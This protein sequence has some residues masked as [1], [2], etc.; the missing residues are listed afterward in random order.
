[1]MVYYIAIM[2]NHINVLEP[3]RFV[4]KAICITL[5]GAILVNDVAFASEEIRSCLAP[6]NF[7][8]PPC[9]ITFNPQ[10]G[11]AVVTEGS[12]E[13]PGEVFLFHTIGA[14]LYQGH[15][16]EELNSLIST[17]I[18]PR[19]SDE[20]MGIYD[21]GEIFMDG[22]DFVLPTKDGKKLYVF[23]KTLP[24]D[25][26][27]T[28]IFI[29]SGDRNVFVTEIWLVRKP[30]VFLYKPEP[31]PKK[32]KPKAEDILTDKWTALRDDEKV[33]AMDA[34]GKVYDVEKLREEY[35]PALARIYS[36]TEES[37]LVRQQAVQ[38]HVSMKGRVANIEI[39]SW[40][41]QLMSTGKT[42]AEADEEL[43]TLLSPDAL[44]YLLK[45]AI[46]NRDKDQTKKLI[47]I[48]KEGYDENF[49]FVILGC[50]REKQGHVFDAERS[51]IT[52]IEH[53]LKEKLQRCGITSEDVHS[54]INQLS[55]DLG[56][57]IIG[58][59]LD[60]IEPGTVKED[61]VF[62]VLGFWITEDGETVSIDVFAHD[63]GGGFDL[64]GVHRSGGS[65]KHMPFFD[66][67]NRV[68]QD[69]HIDDESGRGTLLNVFYLERN[70]QAWSYHVISG[71]SR[72][73]IDNIDVAN[74]SI[75]GIT[76]PNHSLR[77]GCRAEV[78]FEVEKPDLNTDIRDPNL[79]DDSKGGKAADKPT[80]EK[81]GGIAKY[82]A[83]LMSPDEIPFE[84]P[85]WLETGLW[86]IVAISAAMFI[87]FVV[88]PWVRGILKNI[89]ENRS[90]VIEQ[91]TWA[92]EYNAVVSQIE[93]YRKVLLGDESA[94][95]KMDE[96]E[97]LSKLFYLISLI[98]Q[99]DDDP[100]IPLHANDAIGVLEQLIK[101]GRISDD[102]FDLIALGLAFVATNIE[103]FSRKACAVLRKAYY[104]NPEKPSRKK[105]VVFALD[106]IKCSK[107]N[108]F[109]GEV[110]L[111]ISDDE[112][113]AVREDPVLNH[114]SLR[115][116]L[117]KKR[118]QGVES[119][120]VI[121]DMIES[122]PEVEVAI[123]DAIYLADSGQMFIGSAGRLHWQ[124]GGI[125]LRD[126]H[127]PVGSSDE[128]VKG[129]TRSGRFGPGKLYSVLLVAVIGIPLT[130]IC[131]Q[132]PQ[133]AKILLFIASLFFAGSMLNMSR[134]DPVSNIPGA[135]SRTTADAPADGVQPYPVKKKG[136]DA[137]QE[138][139]PHREEGQDEGEP[140]SGYEDFVGGQLELREVLSKFLKSRTDLQTP[141]T[142]VSEIAGAALADETI[143]ALA[144]KITQNLPL[145]AR[146]IVERILSV[147]L[148]R[149]N[150]DNPQSRN[151]QGQTGHIHQ[152]TKSRKV[153]ERRL[154]EIRENDV[155]ETYRYR[156]VA[157]LDS[158]LE[159]RKLNDYQRANLEEQRDR[160]K[161]NTRIYGFQ[162]IVKG[163]H[164][165]FL[166]W[167][168]Y[169]NNEIF[170]AWDL[171]KYL[172]SRGPPSLVDEY[173]LHE[174]ICPH[175]KF[176]PLDRKSHYWSIL[177][178]QRLYTD[179]YPDKIKLASQNKR[180]PYKG[181]LGHAIR[182]YINDNTD[183]V[184]FLKVSLSL[185]LLFELDVILYAALGLIQGILLPEI[186]VLALSAMS[187]SVYTA[188][189]YIRNR[190]Y[191]QELK[192][193][194]SWPQK[195]PLKSLEGVTLLRFN[196]EY[197]NI[198]GI[199]RY[200]QALNRELLKRNRMTII[201]VYYT[202]DQNE[203][204][205]KILDYDMG[206]LVLV[207]VYSKK[208]EKT[209]V[210]GIIKKNA[211][212]VCEALHIKRA[213]K[214]FVFRYAQ[215]I[216]RFP[217]LKNIFK[218]NEFDET[219]MAKTMDKV[220]TE[221]DVDLAGIH[222]WPGAEYPVV[223]AL[224][225]HNIPCYVQ[226]H[227][228]NT[229]L[230]RYARSLMQDPSVIL[231]GVNRREV[232]KEYTSRFTSL[233]DGIDDS[234]FR[235]GDELKGCQKGT[236]TVLLP[237]RIGDPNKGHTD[238][239][240]VLRT[241]EGWFEEDDWE[242]FGDIRIV[243]A[244]PV[245]DDGVKKQI[246]DAAEWLKLS[247]SIQ[248]VGGL[249][250]EEMRDWYAKSDVVVLPTQT[251]GLP[252]VLLE[253]Q[254]MEKPVVAYGVGGVPEAVLNGVSGYV[255]EHGD[256]TSFAKRLKMLLTNPELCARMGEAGRRHVLD[257][258]ALDRLAERHEEFYLKVLNRCRKPARQVRRSF[259]MKLK[260]PFYEK[261]EIV[262]GDDIPLKVLYEGDNLLI[263]DTD[264]LRVLAS[265]LGLNK[266]TFL[267]GVNGVIRQRTRFNR[268]RIKRN[269]LVVLA[270]KKI[271]VRLCSKSK[272]L[273][274]DDKE[275]GVI[276][277]NVDALK[278]L[279]REVPADRPDLYRYIFALFYVGFTHELLGHEIGR[280]NEDE[281]TDEDLVLFDR[282]VVNGS[283]DT[284]TREIVDALR[285]IMSTVVEDGDDE[286]I[287]FER[288]TYEQFDAMRVAALIL[289]P[290]RIADNCIGVVMNN[291]K[292]WTCSTAGDKDV[293]EAALE[294]ADEKLRYVIAMFRKYKDTMPYIWRLVP[295]IIGHCTRLCEAYCD[296]GKREDVPIDER[297][298][299]FNLAGRWLDRA[300]KFYDEF[301]HKLDAKYKDSLARQKEFIR[302]ARTELIAC[303]RSLREMPVGAGG[304]AIGKYIVRSVKEAKDFQGKNQGTLLVRAYD[305]EQ[306][307]DV[308]LRIFA[309]RF[310]PGFFRRYKRQGLSEEVR[311]GLD[312]FLNG[313]EGS[314]YRLAP[315]EYHLYGI[316]LK[317]TLA[318]V[319]PLYFHDVALFHELA[320][321]AIDNGDLSIDM[322]KTELTGGGDISAN[323]VG[324]GIGHIRS[325]RLKAHEALRYFQLV[326]WPSD[327]TSLTV[328]IRKI[329]EL[330]KTDFEE[331][332]EGELFK[333]LVLLMGE[334]TKNGT[335]SPDLCH[336]LMG[337]LRWISTAM[338]YIEDKEIL[339]G[340][341]V[342]V[343]NMLD[344]PDYVIDRDMRNALSAISSKVLRFKYAKDLKEEREKFFKDFRDGRRTDKTRAGLQLKELQKAARAMVELRNLWKE[345]ISGE[346]PIGFDEWAKEMIGK[347]LEPGDFDL[348]ANQRALFAARLRAMRAN[349]MILVKLT[350]GKL[351]SID[352]DLMYKLLFRFTGV[353]LDS[354]IKQVRYNPELP[355]VISFE[356][357]DEDA[358]YRFL[359]VKDDPMSMAGSQGYFD[360]DN[361]VA[362]GYE[363][364]K[365]DPFP[366]E[367]NHGFFAGVWG[368][369]LRPVEIHKWT[370]VEKKFV[371][372]LK[373]GSIQEAA[374]IIDKLKWSLLDELN[375]E[376][377]AAITSLSGR[378][379]S[380]RG[381]LDFYLNICGETSEDEAGIIDRIKTHIN[382]DDCS[383]KTKK[384]LLG[385]LDKMVDSLRH[386]IIQRERIALRIIQE[387][388]D[389]GE[390]MLYLVPLREYS[391]FEG[392]YSY[393]LDEVSVE[394]IEDSVKMCFQTEQLMHDTEGVEPDHRRA[395]IAYWDI[396]NKIGNILYLALTKIGLD[397]SDAFDDIIE[398]IYDG[399]KGLSVQLKRLFSERL[400][401]KR[402][403]AGLIQIFLVML[404][405]SHEEIQGLVR[406]T[407][408]SASK[409]R[410]AAQVR[411]ATKALDQ[412]RKRLEGEDSGLDTALEGDTISAET[413][414]NVLIL[415]ADD[416]LNNAA[417]IDME[418]ALRK[419]TAGSGILKGGK[420]I[421]YTRNDKLKKDVEKLK[422]LIERASSDVN[423]HVVTQ[424][425]VF[426][427]K[428]EGDVDDVNEID[429][430]IK[431]LG[432]IIS[433]SSG[434]AVSEKIEKKDIFAIVRGNGISYPKFIAEY[435]NLF[436]PKER[437]IPVVI[438]NGRKNT[439]RGLFSFECI[440]ARILQYGSG[441]G[442]GSPVIL[443]DCV[444]QTED[445]WDG[446]DRHR[447]RVL[448]QL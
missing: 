175:M 240:R 315:N 310:S 92:I 145:T 135:W 271:K 436:R 192:I 48:I 13:V 249:T 153:F 210:G 113:S 53:S 73:V 312:S 139:P 268:K 245:Y 256:S 253:A 164:D 291:E 319:S 295:Y 241:M 185:L 299:C 21:K 425:T 64:E 198:G 97:A 172:E 397:E 51:K 58:H 251:E 5:V 195:P 111:E 167:N 440:M 120:K 281:L 283:E 317:D 193:T 398:D 326:K 426:K 62:G 109:V 103:D 267:N 383:E 142:P 199:E 181:R 50:M 159:R 307:K 420:I 294:K 46:D 146:N 72:A 197:T 162:S 2:T 148:G 354:G 330:V 100:D 236:K 257:N 87:I 81:N 407:R 357:E 401:R 213:V 136:E 194:R 80:D 223:E 150:I 277:I 263:A 370:F 340:L 77:H 84:I 88:I 27:R 4:F 24:K 26:S 233:Y 254:L 399:D 141:G 15:T 90:A 389:E 373:E 387:Q 207:P 186:I 202:H 94:K 314:A 255:V 352:R 79:P 239:I 39:D 191:Q 390:A 402:K 173:L 68:T 105:A 321:A 217:I 30:T 413:R 45:R 369:K 121:S 415:Y 119:V 280:H 350:D 416:I 25:R 147:C 222:N 433:R 278:R 382:R 225:R 7:H 308:R 318:L 333:Y 43:L 18:D 132:N 187:I 123:S 272:A 327:D 432:N 414:G 76:M 339:D 377:L 386:E 395:C 296:Y 57:N 348:P 279:A 75:S 393:N 409:C 33:K 89:E 204:G 35:V 63:N 218:S 320:H 247:D 196:A 258:F 394:G 128:S 444:P 124:G 259:Q 346:T 10:D 363:S 127:Q 56:P 374:D 316:G 328:L 381:A 174:V 270:E 157:L 290:N 269:D 177:L 221:Y 274:G 447:A 430:L 343:D 19:F 305:L 435:P 337:Y 392:I 303:K 406:K 437:K 261:K 378:L 180:D 231:A 368:V 59:A 264:G 138:G 360:S 67:I 131:C 220:L 276:T 122:K 371:K 448:T 28:D 344:N 287:F 93:G 379:I 419:I 47:E 22:D 52:P 331:Y 412:A 443:V 152:G 364:D 227:G 438:M 206:R 216:M 71:L 86:V 23:S 230:T 229:G 209:T 384:R 388:G 14:S 95:E 428:V 332:W 101:S 284:I 334:E 429:Q 106:I 342:L 203:R 244:G 171:I 345:N 42:R 289:K 282:L 380:R 304:G 44:L 309:E 41:D 8:K 34:L 200:L 156:M 234:L 208:H 85:G 140:Y 252:R 356:F 376:F 134:I 349:Y 201:Q 325:K 178:Q 11:R 410:K 365:L 265:N 189:S 116:D 405:I 423:V 375:C 130:M 38:F 118:D 36:D 70:T 219:A 323:M 96:Y 226:A 445:L 411:S 301:K 184:K 20:D 12:Y 31:E 104:N 441:E 408:K 188:I 99:K 324:Q 446:I 29:I 355:F 169:E 126:G 248:F 165:F 91:Q 40:R 166:G 442:Q 54:C 273:I 1:M 232:P 338:P 396:R 293:K 74:R 237:A 129:I 260:P 212:S 114:K 351:D 367:L 250:P 235:P 16:L 262:I 55:Q 372:Y 285:K 224:K 82:G 242:E 176:L 431:R 6:P 149:N 417:F 163:K 61:D 329:S 66:R 306:E 78:S 292:K 49:E 421:L 144:E 275:N 228:A 115:L 17:I 341:S 313:F 335:V 418:E 362:F 336:G 427:R 322:L 246:E 400:C 60:E 143:G 238:I 69:G 117:R 32:D 179:N 211:V 347:L 160:L 155:T 133:F 288:F 102:I 391:K 434:G 182:D 243:F 110:V 422:T 161:E 158:I 65:R 300:R 9:V 366:H 353:R 98:D 3:K 298:K 361:M 112:F 359:E 215:F 266:Q 205:T 125:A 83:L 37:K 170:I 168:N 358:Y 137:E 424:E 151:G 154:A 297:T 286:S 302:K 385:S 403:L 214:R 439:I 190:S 404:G 311:A 108:A 183:F 107:G